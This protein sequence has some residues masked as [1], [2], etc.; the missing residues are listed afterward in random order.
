M[1]EQSE[2]IGQYTGKVG[3][4]TKR[5]GADTKRVGADSFSVDLNFSS[6]FHGILTG[7]I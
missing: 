7:E 3:F 2:N 4:D 5:V 6:I 1:P